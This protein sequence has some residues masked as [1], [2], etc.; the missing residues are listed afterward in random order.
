MRSSIRVGDTEVG[1]GLLNENR[2]G[3]NATV[4]LSKGDFL[5]DEPGKVHLGY[6]SRPRQAASHS[7]TLCAGE[8][9]PVVG[10]GITLA[11]LVCHSADPVFENGAVIGETRITQSVLRDNGTVTGLHFT[12]DVSAFSM[13]LFN[14]A[15]T[16]TYDGHVVVMKLWN[17]NAGKKAFD[18]FLKLGPEQ[19]GGAPAALDTATLDKRGETASGDV[20]SGK[21][22]VGGLKV[23]YTDGSSWLTGYIPIYH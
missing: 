12:A 16:H 23:L 9:V 3:G 4:Y 11:N 1:P 15:T 7:G 10:A 6:Q 8:A 13:R 5:L 19:A 2:D 17:Q 21:S 14:L 20:T 18:A 22:V